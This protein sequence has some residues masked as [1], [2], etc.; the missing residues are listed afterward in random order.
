MEGEVSE[1]SRS[2]RNLIGV[3]LRFP[4]TQR[5]TMMLTNPIIVTK[6]TGSNRRRRS[7]KSLLLISHANH[8]RQRYIMNI[9][10]TFQC[11]S[12]VRT[13]KIRPCYDLLYYNYKASYRLWKVNTLDLHII[14]NGKTTN[15]LLCHSCAKPSF[16]SFLHL[17][18]IWKKDW[19]NSWNS[20][21]DLS[22]KYQ[23]C[24]FIIVT[25]W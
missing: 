24:S 19:T 23:I 21:R 5:Q 4:S 2:N 18:I 1:G 13:I 14:R 25:H 22:V 11:K 9:F 10:Y 16:E 15:I 6:S 8:V 3:D 7:Y 20:R 12:R 17:I